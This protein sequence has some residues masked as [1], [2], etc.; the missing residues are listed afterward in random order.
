MKCEI[1]ISPEY[2]EPWAE[3]YSN[4]ENDEITR[5][6]QLIE[7]SCSSFLTGYKNDRAVIISPEKII[8]VYSEGQK[9]YAVTDDD[10]FRLRLRLYEAEEYLEK[11]GFVRISASEIIALK[12]AESFD[13]S[14]AGTICVRLKNGESSYVSRRFVKSIKKRL[15]I[16]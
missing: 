13:L 8:R 7:N 9:I 16:K 15:G 11:Y 10:T 2:N 6:V 4:E 3:I 5:L 1:N 12:K 14:I